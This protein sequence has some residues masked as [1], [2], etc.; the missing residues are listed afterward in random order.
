MLKCMPYVHPAACIISTTH[1]IESLSAAISD[2]NSFAHSP[3][4]TATL[5]ISVFLIPICMPLVS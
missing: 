5:Q 3:K 1:I 4:E 2:C